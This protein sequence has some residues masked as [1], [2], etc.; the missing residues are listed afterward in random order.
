[1]RKTVQVTLNF[2]VVIIVLLAATV[3]SAS[4]FL[5]I[6]IGTHLF[7]Q[8]FGVFFEVVIIGIGM[9]FFWEFR[10]FFKRKLHL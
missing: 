3:A 9:Y 4:A 6:E 1:M 5:T 10:G 2:F 7:G 8:Y